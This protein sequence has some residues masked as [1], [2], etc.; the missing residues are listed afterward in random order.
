M[1]FRQ[2]LLDL[3][4]DPAAAVTFAAVGGAL[5]FFVFFLLVRL[6]WDARQRKREQEAR[7]REEQSPSELTLTLPTPEA[8]KSWARRFDERM[9]RLADAADVGL[10]GPQWMGLTLLGGAGLASGLYLWREELP[11]AVGGFF[12]GVG[13]P[14][15]VLALVR[16]RLR[17]QMQQQL[18]DA[19]FFLARSLRAGLSFEQA[20][21]LAASECPQPL[22]RE[23]HRISEQLKLGLAPAAAVRGAAERMGLPDFDIFVSALGLHSTTGGNLAMLLDKLA[24]STR[25]RNQYQG[26]FRSAT[27]LGRASAIAIGAAVPVLFLGYLFFEPTYAYRFFESATGLALLG[28]AFGLEVVGALWLWWLLRV[29]Y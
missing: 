5:L 28:T 24:A 11:F 4:L 14:L 23:L 15:F 8:E 13:L 7:N 2:Y 1:N 9:Q 25:D 29:D 18:P 6:A 19:Y 22:A 3:N 10:T 26:Y 20:M 12:V 21:R 27:A 17:R 16:H